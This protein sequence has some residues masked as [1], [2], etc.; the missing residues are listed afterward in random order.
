MKSV[1]S[2]KKLTS[3]QKDLL[4]HAAVSLVDYNAI[5]ID[6]VPFEIPQNIQNAIF[7]S[8]NAV[9]LERVKVLATMPWCSMY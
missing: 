9:M 2:T 6:F 3:F 5:K 1:L 7:T 4:R 8:Q